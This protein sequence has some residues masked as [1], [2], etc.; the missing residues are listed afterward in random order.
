MWQREEVLDYVRNSKPQCDDCI[1]ERLN[2]SHRQVV[3][4]YARLHC[5]DGKNRRHK[6]PCALGKSNKLVNEAVFG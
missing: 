5:A 6:G 1:A 4:T 3:N 2:Y